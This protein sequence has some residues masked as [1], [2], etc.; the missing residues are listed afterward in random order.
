MFHVH[1]GLAR[2]LLCCITFSEIHGVGDSV[3]MLTFLLRQEKENMV[4]CAL[5][6]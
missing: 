2:S 3:F 5:D 4:N 6:F 1:Q